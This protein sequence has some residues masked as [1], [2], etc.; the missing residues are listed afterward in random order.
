MSYLLHYWFVQM[1][2][3]F[4]FV[5]LTFVY[6]TI[7]DT[8]TAYDAGISVV[9][10]FVI[11]LIAL[12]ISNL[13]KELDHE[14]IRL[15][16]M[17]KTS[18]WL[19]PLIAIVIFSTLVGFAVPKVEPQW[20]D[21]VPFIHSAAEGAG[22]TGAATQKVGYGEDDSRLG[23]SFV[24][25]YTPVFTANVHDS[26]YWRVETK[27]L[28]TGKGWELSSEP[29]YEEL[30]NGMIGLEM[31]SD[32]VASESLTGLIE[33]HNPSIGKL[34]YPYGATQAEELTGIE[35]SFS[36]DPNS[37]AVQTE[38][39][40]TPEMAVY[41][42]EYDNP[43][44]AIN[45]LRNSSE[46]DPADITDRYTQ[47]PS[48]LPDR[49]GELAEEITADEDSRY[50]K[51]KA[52]E[53]YFSSNGFE[54]QTTDV[55]VPQGN[56]DYVDQFLFESQVGYCDNFSSAM[57][58]M[59]RSLDIPTRWAKGFTS[60]ELIENNVGEEPDVYQVTN[61]NAHSWVEVYFP[62]S[63]WVPFEPTQGFSNPTDFHLGET[64][65]DNQTED[66]VLEAPEDIQEQEE[67]EQEELEEEEAETAFSPTSGNTESGGSNWWFGIIGLA[68]LAV[69]AFFIYKTRY[70]WQTK[71]VSARLAKTQDTETFQDA[72]HYLMKVLNDKGYEKAPDQTLREYA[73]QIDSSYGSKEM[74]QLT[75]YYER[76]LYKNELSNQHV[77]ELTQLWKNLINRIMG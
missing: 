39:N 61:A 75:N 24:Q 64:Q 25:D 58:V 5:L 19:T 54:Y 48:S 71:V 52:I 73:D 77:V 17:K 1:K 30:E 66:D 21:P 68:V 42:V 62:G 70:R 56:Q 76:V 15:A 28:Y 35:T 6:L 29:E 4:L 18:A 40:T 33:L 3:I 46:E 36:L 60:G 37:E 20:P 26:H 23:G 8:F 38:F 34:M 31:F 49:V 65:S 53:R 63:G 45:Q 55:P 13:L 10:S 50:D 11:S 43:S 69:L 27:D 51:A 12:A 2:R 67:E 14:Q 72:Y 22:G 16:W 74:G 57:V 41:Q 32:E 7:L 47:L 44:F 59:L 9:R